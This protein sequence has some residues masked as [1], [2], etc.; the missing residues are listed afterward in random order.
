MASKKIPP[1]K[2]RRMP[3]YL[4]LIKDAKPTKRSK[5]DAL[6]ERKIEKDL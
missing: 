6:K 5:K 1:K 2:V 3:S 4:K